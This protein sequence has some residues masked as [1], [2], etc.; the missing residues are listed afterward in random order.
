MVI[1]RSWPLSHAHLRALARTGMHTRR[2]GGGL[3]SSGAAQERSR[4]FQH[5]QLAPERHRRSRGSSSRSRR[6]REARERIVRE[7]PGFAA[8]V[9]RIPAGGASAGDR[10]DHRR[11]TGGLRAGLAAQ[12]RARR[13]HLLARGRRAIRPPRRRPG[14]AA[15]LRGLRASSPP[16]GS[17]PRSALRQRRRRSRSTRAAASASSASTPTTTRTGRP[18][19][20]TRSPCSPPRNVRRGTIS[21]LSGFDR[22]AAHRARARGAKKRG[23]ESRLSLPNLLRRTSGTLPPVI[24]QT[25]SRLSARPEWRAS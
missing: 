7:R 19:C 15:G 3:M 6:D 14:A 25:L 1:A 8:V 5:E 22:C 16:G 12:E 2:S 9:A 24:M 4:S 10:R 23:T 20:A 18:R 21:R 17:D 13:A 11:R